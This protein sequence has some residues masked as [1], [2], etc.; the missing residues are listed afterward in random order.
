M[1]PFR[2]SSLRRVTKAGA[3]FSALLVAISLAACGSGREVG[4]AG[5]SVTS[6]P[7]KP[8]GFHPTDTT[9]HDDP[10]MAAAD[11]RRI[12]A[13]VRRDRFVREV[14]AGSRV[15][16]SKPVPWVSEGGTELLGGSTDLYLTTAVDLD[17][18]KLPATISPNQKAPPGTPTLFRFIRMWATN[19]KK[20]EVAVRLSDGRV[21]RIEPSGTGYQVTKA[22]LIG[23]PPAGSAYAPEPGY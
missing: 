7:L 3:L 15:R 22:E 18:Q 10:R 19:V 1:L 12:K 4:T 14:S 8:P 17:D 6:G 9:V 21:V 20:L 23:P 2:S 11:A 13:S 16:L 5:R